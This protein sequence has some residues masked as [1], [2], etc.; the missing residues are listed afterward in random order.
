MAAKKEPTF[1]KSLERLEEIVE[2]LEQGEL[3]LEQSLKL[4]EEGVK[5]AD[6]CGQR[7]DEAEKKVT[8]LVKDRDKGLVEEPFPN[9]EAEE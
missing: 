4:F 6:S 7:L 8:L 2:A 1:E 5:L 3:T 9:Q